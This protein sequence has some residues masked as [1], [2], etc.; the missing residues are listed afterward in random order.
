MTALE[1]L[2][3][4]DVDQALAEL[5]AQVRSEPSEPRHRIFL[6]QLLCITGQWDRAL[7]QLNVAQ[8]LDP[9][10]GIMG[11][12]YQEILHCEAI[13]RSVF[14]GTR[15]P[16]IFGDP[17]PWIAQ[18][19]EAL[20]LA[21]EGQADAAN[22]LRQQA[23]ED[24]PVTCGTLQLAK[25]G[26]S[27]TGEDSSVENHE[28]EWLADGD[29]RLGPVI[30]IIINGR[31]YW[32]SQQYIAEIVI[33]PPADLRDLVWV[34]AHFRWANAG[35]AVGVMPTRYVGSESHEDRAVALA[36]KTDWRQM[37][38]DMFEGL[39]QR[40]LITDEGDF[41]LLDIRKISFDSVAEGA[42]SDDAGHVE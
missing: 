16:L 30:E 41:G 23:F 40:V 35:E 14:E 26:S 10:A 5:F 36:R 28:F 20:R 3:S 34:P 13:R 29:S 15:T 21:G 39:G 4:G 17:Q 24:A 12:A 31:Y 11:K 33:D 6:F 42:V 32:A 25:R 18:L 38:Q 2:K 1:L 9:A 27:A 8:D 37:A 19:I 7:T 22:E